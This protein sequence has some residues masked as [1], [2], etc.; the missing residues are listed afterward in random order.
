[1]QLAQREYWLVTAVGALA[2][3]GALLTSP[4]GAAPLGGKSD[5]KS[6]GNREAAIRQT[7][8]RGRHY[9]HYYYG[10]YAP[11]YYRHRY[12]GYG[13]GFYGFVGRPYRWWW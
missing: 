5:L 1:M 8:W 7:H 9:R 2:L 13:P 12:Y 11:R 10:Y 4:A 6:I 3:G